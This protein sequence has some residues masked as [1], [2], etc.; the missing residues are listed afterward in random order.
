MDDLMQEVKMVRGLPKNDHSP[1]LDEIRLYEM[2]DIN[3]RVK[4]MSAI[5]FGTY[6]GYAYGLYSTCNISM[7]CSVGGI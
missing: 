3:A 4:D 5:E 2:Q 1:I 7:A 6:V